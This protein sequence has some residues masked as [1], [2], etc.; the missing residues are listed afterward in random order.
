M[1]TREQ[2]SEALSTAYADDYDLNNALAEHYLEGMDFYL[3]CKEDATDLLESVYDTLEDGLVEH[4]G[5]SEEKELNVRMMVSTVFG[6]T[7]D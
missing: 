2:I 7:I 6:I 3:Y 4:Y 5:D 1:A